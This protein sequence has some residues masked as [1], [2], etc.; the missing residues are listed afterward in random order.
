MST[1]VVLWPLIAL[2]GWVFG[3][4]ALLDAMAAFDWWTLDA[5]TDCV[6]IDCLRRAERRLG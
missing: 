4:L 5:G 2:A 6:S 3:N 1:C